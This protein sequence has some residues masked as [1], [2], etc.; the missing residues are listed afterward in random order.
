MPVFYLLFVLIFILPF[1]LNI[2][3]KIIKVLDVFAVIS[4]SLALNKIVV[5]SYITELK[6]IKILLSFDI[7]SALFIAFGIAFA[8]TGIIFKL[9]KQVIKLNVI[10]LIAII[11]IIVFILFLVADS[12]SLFS[13][14]N[15]NNAVASENS[16]SYEISGLLKGEVNDSS[17]SFRIGIWKNSLDMGIKNPIFGTGVGTY[18]KTFQEFIKG[19]ELSGNIDLTDTA[20]NEYIHLFCTV[21]ITGLFAYLS[22]LLSLAIKAFRKIFKNPYIIIL[23]SA[24]LCYCVQAFFSFNIVIITPL[25]WICSGLLYREAKEEN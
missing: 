18:L 15:G 14:D 7:I 5:L 21:G 22:F 20:H 11:E 10:K 16:L 13:F 1:I 9:K 25:F 4:F 6:K 12:F 19:T 24:V 23:G 3:D 8:V 17:G 2:N